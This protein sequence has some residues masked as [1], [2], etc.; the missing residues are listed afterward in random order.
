MG[1]NES[2]DAGLALIALAASAFVEPFGTLSKVTSLS[3][4]VHVAPLAGSS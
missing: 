4:L 3:A 1:V 2:W